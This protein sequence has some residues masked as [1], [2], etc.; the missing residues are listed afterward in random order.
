M[1]YIKGRHRSQGLLL[2]QTIDDYVADNNGVRAIAA[3][4]ERLDFVKLG[5]VRAEAAA[6]GRPGYDPR[7]LMGLYLWGHLNGVCSSRKL[8][9]ECERNLE[10]IWLCEQLHPDFKTI[11]D[12]RSVNG[13]GIKGVV[14]EFRG[15]CL[16][17]GLYGKEIVAVDGSKFKAVN[18]KQRNYTRA[19]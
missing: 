2:P 6:T 13:V 10:V 3:F 19:K 7:I 9:R 5:F 14:T 4:L 8:A 15:W 18:S 17:A 16:A 12:F 11:A 1:G